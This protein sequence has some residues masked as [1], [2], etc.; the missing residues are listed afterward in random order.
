MSFWP[1]KGLFVNRN[2]RIQKVRVIWRPPER[3][4]TN[5]NGASQ[6]EQ[7]PNNASSVSEKTGT[8]GLSN[9]NLE[10]SLSVDNQDKKDVTNVD[11]GRTRRKRRN[12][13]SPSDHSS[14]S[15]DQKRL[16]G[17]HENGG[18]GNGEINGDKNA[19]DASND[20][21]TIK[22]KLTKKRSDHKTKTSK[23][24]IPVNNALEKGNQNGDGLIRQ[25]DDDDDDWDGVRDSIGP[26]T[27]CSSSS[28]LSSSCSNH[29]LIKHYTNVMMNCCD[30]HFKEDCDNV[31]NKI[32][33]IL[34]AH[35]KDRLNRVK[36]KST[37]LNGTLN[38]N[39]NGQPNS[40]PP[41]QAPQVNSFAFELRPARLPLNKKTWSKLR[42]SNQNS[43]WLL[44][45]ES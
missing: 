20:V 45:S 21:I 1:G 41:K 39:S 19:S 16:N 15:N 31:R 18:K 28:S 11:A 33:R 8:N 22:R 13:K 30:N 32:E 2:K 43:D 9:D 36:E 17:K 40:Q 25:M 3:S 4:D 29:S 35:W 10:P 24:V 23:D 12:L 37:A 5:S 44:N 27:R 38:G 7:Q 26:M 42:R 34:K 6:T 14:N